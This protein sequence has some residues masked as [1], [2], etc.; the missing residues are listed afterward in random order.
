MT[1]LRRP[2]Y[3]IAAS[4]AKRTAAAL[5]ELARMA[6]RGE[7]IGAAVA[8]WTGADGLDLRVIGFLEQR[9]PM[10]HFAASRLAFAALLPEG[11]GE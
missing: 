11:G 3:A 5:R 7:L 9:M 4:H 1:K 6:D 2:P 10:A 8:G